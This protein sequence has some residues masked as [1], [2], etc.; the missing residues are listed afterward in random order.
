M[1]PALS[2]A[3]PRRAFSATVALD[4]D[5]QSGPDT[6]GHIPLAA[7]SGRVGARCW[8][9]PPHA[10]ALSLAP[11]RALAS[12]ER[13]SDDLQEKVDQFEE[14]EDALRERFQDAMA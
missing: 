13:V 12:I 5:P 1:P 6:S 2:R 10:G 7:R 4:T 8:L 9:G 11:G 3:T 14:R